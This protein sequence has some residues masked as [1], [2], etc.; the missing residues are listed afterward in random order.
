MDVRPVPEIN[1]TTYKWCVRAFSVLHDRLGI[2][3]KVHGAEGKIDDGQIFLFNHFARF[4]TVIPQY[5]IHEATGAFC[6]CV[7]ASELFEGNKTFAKLLWDVGA[8][9]TNL[10][11]L[12]PFL[13]ADILRGRKVIVFPEGGMIKDRHVVDEQ[14]DFGVFSPMALTQRKLHKGAAAIALTLEIF[15]KRILMV[16]D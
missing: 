13:A 7:A 16:H 12:L 5:I 3:L 11:G 6:R 1:E 4:E 9:P 10:P 15:K 14:G 2:N 8:V